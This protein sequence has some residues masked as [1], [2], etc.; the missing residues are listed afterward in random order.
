LHFV[1]AVIRP[2]TV[3]ASA[4]LFR[5]DGDNS[6]PPRWLP[7]PPH[8][9]RICGSL[10]D[11]GSR[12]QAFHC[13]G[14]Q[15]R[16]GQDLSRRAGKCRLA[17]GKNQG[18]PQGNGRNCGRTCDVIVFAISVCERYFCKNHFLNISLLF[19]HFCHGMKVS[20]SGQ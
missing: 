2:D 7:D 19:H 17:A 1:V 18:F 10:P 14:V 13:R 16:I 20:Q 11:P 15:D 5:N 3:R 6:D 4:P 9:R 8:V 12:H